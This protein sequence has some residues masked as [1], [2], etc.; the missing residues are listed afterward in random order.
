[1]IEPK[2]GRPSK[3]MAPGERKSISFRVTFDVYQRL[4]ADAERTGRSISECAEQALQ[5]Q[6]AED[7]MRAIAREEIERAQSQG[8]KDRVASL[9]PPLT[10]T[11]W[12]TAKAQ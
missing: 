4:S 9:G 1:M 12:M 5:A 2:R 3:A 11:Q 7:R 6:Y 8:L 10:F